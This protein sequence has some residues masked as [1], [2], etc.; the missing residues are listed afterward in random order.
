MHVY[1]KYGV[2]ETWS[3]SIAE[4]IVEEGEWKWLTRTLSKS[5]HAV[6]HQPEVPK[7]D[8]LRAVGQRGISAPLAQ[9]HVGADL[10]DDKTFSH[11]KY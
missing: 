11:R 8:V 5:K 2:K 1:T 6:D 4:T 7:R 3:A 10:E 9:P